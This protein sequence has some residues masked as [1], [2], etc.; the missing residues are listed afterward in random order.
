M[1]D[2][3]YVYIN[4]LVNK[5]KEDNNEALH[6]LYFFYKPLILSA[7]RRCCSKERL[8]FSYRDD[9]NNE[10]I[11]VLRSLVEKYDSDLS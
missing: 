5:I 6:E 10:S 11:F 4:S 7:I 9:L 2:E 1:I 8:L 3:H